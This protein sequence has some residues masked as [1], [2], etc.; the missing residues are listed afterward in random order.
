MPSA[1]NSPGYPI[2]RLLCREPAVAYNDIAPGHYAE[3]PH[4]FGCDDWMTAR[5]MTC[6]ELDNA[7]E[8]AGEAKVG[9]YVE[10]VTDA[11]AA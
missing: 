6:A 2:E 8:A 5:V 11:Y 4:A 1:R 3:L 7:L 9:V 10:V